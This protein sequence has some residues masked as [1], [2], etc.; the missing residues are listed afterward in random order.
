MVGV[1][2]EEA[3]TYLVGERGVVVVVVVVVKWCVTIL[4][5]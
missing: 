4:A 1:E 3:C 5:N 2:E